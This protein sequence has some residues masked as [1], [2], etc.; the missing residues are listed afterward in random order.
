[1]E[2]R[3]A[4][5]GSAAGKRIWR[6]GIYATPDIPTAKNQTK[7]LDYKA[8]FSRSPCEKAAWMRCVAPAPPVSFAAAINFFPMQETLFERGR[9]ADVWKVQYVCRV[10]IWHSRR[11]LAEQMHVACIWIIG[12]G[13][14]SS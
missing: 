9:L 11:A 13:E 1:V 12:L 8:I 2:C 14:S 7:C 10:T 3:D 4:I 6:R 5:V